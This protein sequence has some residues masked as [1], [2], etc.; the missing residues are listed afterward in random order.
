VRAK[1][2]VGQGTWPAIWMLGNNINTVSWPACGEIDIMEHL[3]RDLNKIYATLHYPGRSGGNADG[4]SKIISNATTAF[5]IYTLEWTSS[6]IKISVDGDL[7]HSVVNSSSIPFNQNFFLIM[8]IAMGGNFG[9]PVDP[10]FTNASMEID[11]V[12]VYQ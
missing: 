12:R 4:N 11:Y 1:I 9:G 10:A 6:L 3:G 8:N 5:H 7:I 2:P